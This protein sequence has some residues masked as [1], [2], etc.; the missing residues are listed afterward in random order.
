[1]S[2][3]GFSLYF[4]RRWPVIYWMK[5]NCNFQV[6]ETSDSSPDCQNGDKKRVVAHEG[7]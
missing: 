1:M 3:I 2:P 5:G 4:D 7:L 6:L